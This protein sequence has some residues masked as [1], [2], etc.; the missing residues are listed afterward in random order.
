MYKYVKLVFQYFY[1]N[2]LFFFK[3]CIN[4]LTNENEKYYQVIQHLK[5]KYGQNL[6]V[7][8]YAETQLHRNLL[9]TAAVV[10]NFCD[11]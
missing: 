9:K 10:R 5:L 4:F 11:Q 3:F 6:E 8:L 7:K 2:L 1:Q